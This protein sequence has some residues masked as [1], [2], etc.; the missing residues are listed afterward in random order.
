MVFAG[1]KLSDDGRLVRVDTAAAWLIGHNDG[2]CFGL[3]PVAVDL[4]GSSRLDLVCGGRHGLYWLENLGQGN[5]VAKGLTKDPL[6]FPSYG[7]RLKLLVVKDEAG[8]E[9]PA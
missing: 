4:T 8:R 2:V 7:D 9:K 6:W 3:D 1:F 5:G